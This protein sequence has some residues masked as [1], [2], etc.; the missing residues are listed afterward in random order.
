[1]ISCYK[2]NTAYDSTVKEH[3]NKKE[4]VKKLE[5]RLFLNIKQMLNIGGRL[6]E[7]T[8]FEGILNKKKKIK[9]NFVYR[10]N[11]KTLQGSNTVEIFSVIFKMPK[12]MKD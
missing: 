9:Q 3:V 4:N 6:P 1:M 11:R 12:V 10:G 7:L 8:R 2:V 5:V